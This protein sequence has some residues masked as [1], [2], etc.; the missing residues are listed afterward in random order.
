MGARDFKVRPLFAEPVFVTNIANAI[1]PQH[2]AFV[3]KQKMLKNQANLISEEAALLDRTQ[4][5][6]V[7]AVVDEVLATDAREVMGMEQGL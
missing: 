6:A 1:T 5:A 3:K 2:E 4:L 7:R